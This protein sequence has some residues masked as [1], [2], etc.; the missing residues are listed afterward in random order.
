MSDAER[1]AGIGVVVPEQERPPAAEGEFYQSD[2][3]GAE[4]VD[5]AGRSIGRVTGWKT[6]GGPALLEV[7]TESGRRC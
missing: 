3:I 7:R 4:V 1:L 2:L 6:Y 5:R